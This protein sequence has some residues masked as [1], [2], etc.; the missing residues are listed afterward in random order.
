MSSCCLLLL[1]L[2]L[3]L[4]VF[5]WTGEDHNLPVV[6]LSMELSNE[7]TM[8]R[9]KLASVFAEEGVLFVLV[10]VVAVLLF[11]FLCVVVALL[12]GLFFLPK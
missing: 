11:L 10:L 8:G 12:A 1:L 9:S 5:C 6:L 2:L 4:F 3:S 7:D